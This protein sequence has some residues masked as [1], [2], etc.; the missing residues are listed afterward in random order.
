VATIKKRDLVP[1]VLYLVPTI[2]IGYGYVIPKHGID[3]WNELT[4]G[5]GGAIL[6]A[7]VTYL[8]GVGAARR[9]P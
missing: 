6:G 7:V 9:H 2:G 8:V 5:F 3:G 1:L 4:V